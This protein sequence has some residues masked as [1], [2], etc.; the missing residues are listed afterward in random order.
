[1]LLEF[2]WVRIGFLLILI[3]GSACCW[4]NGS[5]SPQNN[6][7]GR[8]QRLNLTEIGY[9]PANTDR[10]HAHYYRYL[11]HAIKDITRYTSIDSIIDVGS[12]SFPFLKHF[13]GIPHRTVIAPYFYDYSQSI[14]IAQ[15]NL[16]TMSYSGGNSNK[17]NSNIATIN[18]DFMSPNISVRADMVLCTQ[19]LEHIA[20]PKAFFAKLYLSARLYLIVSVP[21][22]WPALPPPDEK[23][24][25]HHFINDTVLQGW[26][27]GKVPMESIIVGERRN[28]VHDLYT[29]RLIATYKK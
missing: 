3:I 12:G 15:S 14:V 20:D 7:K 5:T 21:F 16:T 26:A 28:Q 6:H 11:F 17:N 13:P 29:K 27:G 24:H 10:S 23:E 22:M 4:K 2:L 8:H 19:V 1:M 25:Q 18:A 9:G